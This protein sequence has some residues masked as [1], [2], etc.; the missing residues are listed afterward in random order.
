MKSKFVIGD[1]VKVVSYGHPIWV[2]KN[3]G[4]EMNFP[5]ISEDD[6]VVWYDING[7]VVGKIGIVEKVKET[8]GILGYSLSGIPEKSAW[9]NEDQLEAVLKTFKT[10]ER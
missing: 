3:S 2:N 7:G 1:K 8:Q 9:Y 6:K 10:K 5:I 4:M